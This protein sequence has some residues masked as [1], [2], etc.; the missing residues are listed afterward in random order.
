MNVG[1]KNIKKT[2]LSKNKNQNKIINNVQKPKKKPI[3]QTKKE[4][5]TKEKVRPSLDLDKDNTDQH[6]LVVKQGLGDFITEF[7]SKWF[8]FLKS[9]FLGISLGL[10]KIY[11]IQ[12]LL[13]SLLLGGIFALGY[14]L[15]IVNIIAFENY[16]FWIQVVSLSVLMGLG[17]ISIFIALLIG[18]TQNNFIDKIFK[19]EKFSVVK[20]SKLNVISYIKL[21]LFY[22]LLDFVVIGLPLLI[23]GAILMLFVLKKF[24][25]AGIL[26][27]YLLLL[28]VFLIFFT[29][30]A[31]I[32]FFLKFIKWEMFIGK[33]GLGKSISVSIQE[34]KKNILEVFLIPFI[35]GSILGA[36][37]FI[38]QVLFRIGFVVLQLITPSL[39]GNPIVLVLY[40]L[41]GLIFGIL[42]L[43][44][45]IILASIN[46]SSSY[47]LW[48]MTKRKIDAINLL[49]LRGEM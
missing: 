15:F 16:N 8:N 37:T 22:T 30:L 19:K 26:G 28:L 14:F 17:F 11:S 45:A 3:V 40:I 38:V 34:V 7:F 32:L 18:T 42:L 48:R 13:L 33:R 35:I 47:V 43:I 31:I 36:F 5:I 49:K 21:I 20:E 1:S 6:K 44:C 27:S 10:F 41:I 2:V 9:D 46:L 4:N 29:I 12:I 24:S 25:L 39:N 23:I